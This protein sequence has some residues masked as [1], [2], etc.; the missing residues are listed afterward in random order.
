LLDKQ[1]RLHDRARQTL[2]WHRNNDT[3]NRH[4]MNL[5]AIEHTFDVLSSPQNW[6]IGDMPSHVAMSA[7]DNTSDF[8]S[9]RAEF[10]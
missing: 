3:V 1:K 6:M 5:K 10:N 7:P 2:E 4:S 9:P 8:H